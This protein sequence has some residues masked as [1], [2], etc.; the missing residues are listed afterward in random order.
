MFEDALAYG[1][2]TALNRPFSEVLAPDL[3]DDARLFYERMSRDIAVVAALVERPSEADAIGRALLD[4]LTATA[5][6]RAAAWCRLYRSISVLVAGSPCDPAEN[7][8]RKPASALG[9]LWQFARENGDLDMPRFPDA[10]CTAR[11]RATVGA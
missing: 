11:G 3:D 9:R 2:A 4:A 5:P 1:S 6:A 10:A 7:A 8:R